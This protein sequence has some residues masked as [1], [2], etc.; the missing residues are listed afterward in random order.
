MTEAQMHHNQFDASIL[1][2]ESRLKRYFLDFFRRK[3][4]NVRPG[5]LTPDELRAIVKEIGKDKKVNIIRVEY[6]GTPEDKPVSVKI[7]DIR[8][9]YFTGVIVNLER[10]IKQEMNDKLVFV[11]G[12]GGTIDFYFKDGDIKSVEQDIDE[13]ILEPKNP[14]ELLEILDALDLDEAILLSFYDRDKGGVMN[15]T[16]KLV[17]KDIENKTFKVELN[18]INDI[19]LDVPKTINLDLEKD[20]VLDLEV[21]I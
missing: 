13:S 18:L 15:G 10:S 16:G 11:K 2:G 5:A 20:T 12:G 1:N 21:V 4:S 19:E 17:A 7:V 3:K 14:D 8:D 9:D 6:D